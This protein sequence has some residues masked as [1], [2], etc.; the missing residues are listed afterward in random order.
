MS[1][2][3]DLLKQYRGHSGR[4]L[5]SVIGLGLFSGV[6]LIGQAYI[7]ANI[8]HGIIIKQQVISEF[9][10]S[11]W[12]L[13]VLI[14]IRAAL[15]YLSEQM[16]VAGAL[17]I[18]QAIRHD[19]L[20]HINRLGPAYSRSWS[21]GELVTLV[22]EATDGLEDYYARFLPTMALAA[23]IPVAILVFVFPV[24]WQAAVIFMVTAPLIP[25]FMVLIGRGTEKRNQAQWHWLQRL[26]GYFLDVIQ[27]LSTL[28]IFNTSQREAKM[29][30]LMS[31]QYRQKTMAVLRVA[32]LSALALEFFATI[33]IAL[34]AVLIGFRLLFGELDFS[35]GFFVLL[36]AP[37]FYIPLRALG[38][39]YHARMNAVASA[40][41]L[42]EVLGQQSNRNF[43][44]K[45][46]LSG[47]IKQ[48]KCQDLVYGFDDKHNVLEGISFELDAGKHL[49]IVG[50]SGAGKSTL[51]NILAGFI[52]V[53]YQAL[54][55]NGIPLNDLNLPTWQHRLTWLSQQTRL[56]HGSIREN[57][58][59][60]N[61]SYNDSEIIEAMK[62]AQIHELVKTLPAGL[63]TVVA[64]GGRQ[65]SGGEIQRL[66]I[67]RA[68]LS[69]AEL[70]LMDEPTAHLDKANELAVTEALT[71]LNRGRTVI[72]VAHRLHTI[73][74]ADHILVLA[75]AKQQQYG[76]HEQLKS[77]PGLY[78]ELLSKQGIEL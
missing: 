43:Q 45:Q 5:Y 74:K 17:K 78:Q 73:E 23:M 24:D 56:M 61:A 66:M 7:L 2:A 25:F 42:V 22:I 39:Q 13:L 44:G 3:A 15:A 59:L 19:L 62:Q 50:P 75:D 36:L 60:G 47:P 70:V 21:S 35:T 32:F 14:L 58:T 8:V 40:E 28:K 64:D 57:L 68:I 26:G 55:I 46:S 31:D 65:L 10:Q 41:K 67:A 63:D 6:L 54:K 52:Q 20:K 34:V 4:L 49:A 18:R 33:S 11:L 72:T 29:I 16:A 12:A 37:E 76:T 30:A 1:T 38:S 77:I 53:P 48:I 9:Q 27:G 71:H 69:N 51:L